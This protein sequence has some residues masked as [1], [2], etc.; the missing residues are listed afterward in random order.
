MVHTQPIVH[1]WPRCD[2][3]FPVLMRSL[4]LLLLLLLFT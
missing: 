4:L 1:G 2:S 3:Y